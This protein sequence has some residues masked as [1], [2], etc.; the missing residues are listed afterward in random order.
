MKKGLIIATL[1][2]LGICAL[3]LII[4]VLQIANLNFLTG[5]LG[6]VLASVATLTAAGYFSIMSHTMLSKNKISRIWDFL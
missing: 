4:T 3:M 5:T 6:Q 1:A 2:G